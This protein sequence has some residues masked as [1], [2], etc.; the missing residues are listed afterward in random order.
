MNAASST[1]TAERATARVLVMPGRPQSEPH[2][3]AVPASVVAAEDLD[4]VRRAV[5]GDR[6]AM[7]WLVKRVMPRVRRIARA[8]V[9]VAADADDAAQNALV[10]IVRSLPSYRGR[11][12]F[13]NWAKR[14]AVRATLRYLESERRRRVPGEVGQPDEFAAESSGRMK[15]REALPR[16]VREYLTE[17]PEAQRTAIVLRYA[18]DHSIEEIA[19]LT[20]VSPNTVKGRLRLGTKALRKSVRREIG[21]GARGQGGSRR[22][23][24]TS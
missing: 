23:G 8:L 4:L 15:L 7:A 17:L 24:G 10:R 6:R 22:D 16:D 5:E 11:S 19:A 9:R 21:I 18:L 3:D 20:D 13:E 12:R 1:S 14:I 2:P